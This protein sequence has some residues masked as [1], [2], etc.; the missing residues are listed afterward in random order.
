MKQNIFNKII[1]ISF[2]TF[3]FVTLLSV[4]INKSLTNLDEIWNYNTARVM[5]EGLLPY[6]D[7]SMI[8]T[9]LLPAITAVILKITANQLFVSRILSA[10]IGSAIILIIYKIFD[11]LL[12]NKTL[13]ILCSEIITVFLIKYICID[14]NFICLLICLSTLFL[15]LKKINSINEINEEKNHDMNNA[16]IASLKSSN[17]YN[18]MIG[19]LGGLAICTKQ[20]IG[21][22]MSIIL[23]LYPLIFVHNKTLAKDYLKIVV[24]R[25]IGIIIPVLILFSYLIVTNSLNDFINYAILGIKTFSNKVSYINLINSKTKTISAFSI[26]FPI[27][28]LALFANALIKWII[29]LKKNKSFKNMKS[30]NLLSLTIYLVPM[31]IVIYPISDNIHF[32]IGTVILAVTIMYCIIRIINIILKQIEKVGKQKIY[33]QILKYFEIVVVV[34]FTLQ[35]G[36]HLIFKTYT[37]FMEYNNKSK[38]TM[39]NHYKNVYIDENLAMKIETI[40]KYIKEQNEKNKNVYILD[41]EAAIYNIPIDKYNKNYDM[42]LKGN[43]GKDDEEGI[44]QNIRNSENCIY[45]VKK[46]NYS[47]NWQTPKKVIEYVR[48]NLTKLGEIGIFD[49]FEQ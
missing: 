2:T 6:K 38:N 20:T 12:K 21:I 40:D 28:M 16:I 26:F 9:P 11:L 10:I 36:Y 48:T 45:L 15:E 18:I 47:L 41:A 31:L 7:V 5:S 37:N 35:E 4:T 39:L 23:V 44:I 14:Y 46:E 13:S 8:T 33:N 22:V 32:F 24:K 29:N 27:A 49:I 42:F 30:I 19:M 17:V 1:T 34:F 3:V 43:I 25:L